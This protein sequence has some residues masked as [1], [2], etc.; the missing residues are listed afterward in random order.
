MRGVASASLTTNGSDA[1]AAPHQSSVMT[2]IL[3]VGPD[4]DRGE[5]GEEPFLVR[6]HLVDILSRCHALGEPLLRHHDGFL[7]RLTCSIGD[8]DWSKTPPV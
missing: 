3:R 7:P 6:G 1:I 5:R 8:P 2:R 4:R